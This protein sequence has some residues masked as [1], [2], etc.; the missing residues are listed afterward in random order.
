MKAFKKILCLI[1]IVFLLLPLIGAS[2]FAVGNDK[3]VASLRTSE[4]EK[5]SDEQ[6]NY[7]NLFESA[8][9]S[10]GVCSEGISAEFA[11]AFNADA[12]GW[13]R[14]LA[15]FTA[16]EENLEKICRM[17]VYGMSYGDPRSFEEKLQVLKGEVQ[18]GDEI[19]VIELAL[20][21]LNTYLSSQTDEQSV[22]APIKRRKFYAKTIKKLIDANLSTHNFHEQFYSVIGNVYRTAPDEAAE[23]LCDYDESLPYLVKAIAYDCKKS[24][25]PVNYDAV[26]KE[27]LSE[28]Q[29]WIL[30]LL[31]EEISSDRDFWSEYLSASGYTEIERNIE[32]FKEQ[33]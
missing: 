7:F 5:E 23:I 30:E 29:A 24:G 12:A 21:A 33:L 3:E 1:L 31:R 6:T 26:N 28:K 25:E 27:Q 20:T 2:A 10:D 14:A 22:P 32:R 18:S 16:E 17:L 19:K 9:H 11:A 13:I 4:Q 15:G 8:L